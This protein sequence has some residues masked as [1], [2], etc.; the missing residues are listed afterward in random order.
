MVILLVGIILCIC[1]AANHVG[2]FGVILTSLP[3]DRL[4][5]IQLSTGLGDGATAPFW[6]FLIGGLFLYTCYYG[7]D[8]SQVQR[9][10]SAATTNET[11]RSPLLN[12]K[13][14]DWISEHIALI[15]YFFVMISFMFLL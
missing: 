10:L 4:Q 7:T 2:G 15:V 1:Y 5:A 11:K 12:K 9:E 6:A 14:R 3:E 13:E 8:Q